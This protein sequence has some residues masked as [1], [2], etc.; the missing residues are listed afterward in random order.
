MKTVIKYVSV[1]VYQ[2]K[3]STMVVDGI[4][5]A[6]EN[7]SFRLPSGNYRIKAS[8][9]G[10]LKTVVENVTIGNFQRDLNLLDLNSG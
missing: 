4:T 3:Y 5:D 9:I 2:Q 7:F 10:Y 8:F 1:A 6:N